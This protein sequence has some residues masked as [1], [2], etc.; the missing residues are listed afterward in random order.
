L[1]INKNNIQ[2][3]IL[4]F[5]ILLILFNNLL[6]YFNFDGLSIIFLLTELTIIVVFIL[7][8]TTIYTKL[9]ILTKNYKL[10]YLFINIL[11]LYIYSYNIKTLT[12]FSYINYYSFLS[13]IVQND[14][15]FIYYFFFINY[16]F[17]SFFLIVILSLF[18]LFFIILFFNLK[19]IKNKLKI[20]KK[21]IFFLKKQELIE[22]INFT[23]QLRNFQN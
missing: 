3:K 10:N 4:Y 9:I 6:L 5:F 23:N 1:F 8:Y 17:I 13:I 19:K 2:K 12:T 21:K 20:D 16:L 11:I 18:S 7:V 15:F 22:Q 14:F